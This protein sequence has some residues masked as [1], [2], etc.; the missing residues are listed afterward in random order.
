M[1]RTLIKETG[2]YD[3]T[4]YKLTNTS[5]GK[6]QYSAHYRIPRTNKHK[7]GWFDTLQEAEQFITNGLRTI[8][9]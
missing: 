7:G 1:E 9:D 6:T 5:L 2:D 4:I 8:Q 3:T